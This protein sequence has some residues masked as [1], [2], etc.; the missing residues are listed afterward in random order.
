V[1]FDAFLDQVLG[2]LGTGKQAVFHIGH[3][4]QGLG[5][6]PDRFHINDTGDIDAA[7]ADKDPDSGL[8]LGDVPF[9]KLGLGFGQGA[10]GRGQKLSGGCRPSILTKPRRITQSL[11]FSQTLPV[12]CSL[13]ERLS[14]GDFQ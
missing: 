9:G 1:L 11:D 14:P 13:Q 3:I 2:V 8:F 7:V 5:I 4:G 10:P 12:S 6:V